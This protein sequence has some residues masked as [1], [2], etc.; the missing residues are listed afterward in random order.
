MV[1]HG[2]THV[3]SCQLKLNVM[4]YHTYCH[5]GFDT[6][7]DVPNIIYKLIYIYIYMRVMHTIHI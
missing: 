1:M 4:D 3:K 5:I 2:N 6:K 7:F